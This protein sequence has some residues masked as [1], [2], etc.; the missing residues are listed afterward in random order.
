MAVRPVQ[1]LSAY[2]RVH[3]NLLTFSMELGLIQRLKEM[4][5]RNI[6]WGLKGAGA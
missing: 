6:F 3:F 5:T 2:K 4:S 1:S